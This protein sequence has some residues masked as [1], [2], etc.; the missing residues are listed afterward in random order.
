MPAKFSTW[1]VIYGECEQCKHVW[2]FE[3]R[4][5]GKRY[6]AIMSGNE[7]RLCKRCKDAKER[8]EYRYTCDGCGVQLRGQYEDLRDIFNVEGRSFCEGCMVAFYGRYD[9]SNPA[10]ME[11][12]ANRASN[13][14]QRTFANLFSDQQQELFREAMA[15]SDLVRR[16]SRA[17]LKH[18][19]KVLNPQGHKLGRSGEKG[20]YQL[21]HIIPVLVCW[22]YRVSDANASA[23]GNL[24][25]IP[26]FV[27]LSRGGGLA[28]ETLIG[29]PYPRKRRNRPSR[30]IGGRQEGSPE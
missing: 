1:K 16:R 18:F 30:A 7:P 22:Q 15:Y 13:K 20:A 23:I 24:Q 17:N 4:D 2:R 19:S 27:N 6:K 28:L 26:W 9:P 29:W 8:G 3:G 21:D 14:A 10:L 25:V 11:L 12:L 5:D